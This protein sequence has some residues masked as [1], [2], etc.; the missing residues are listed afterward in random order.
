MLAR[1]IRSTRHSHS[2]MVDKDGVLK[3][4]ATTATTTTTHPVVL[5][6]P[7][8]AEET[9]EY[10]PRQT[11][12]ASYASNLSPES[13]FIWEK[14]IK[15]AMNIYRH[16]YTFID[17]RVTSVPKVSTVSS[18]GIARVW[19]KPSLGAALRSSRLWHLDAPRI[20][21]LLPRKLSH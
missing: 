10:S 5:G 18:R 11:L 6:H 7:L 16:L 2:V 4:S 1:K 12:D 19:S 8:I 14:T 3:R 15:Y 21:C 17:H 9:R 13:D 20:A